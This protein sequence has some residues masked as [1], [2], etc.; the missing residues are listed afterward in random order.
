[1][2]VSNGLIAPKI[3]LIW[4]AI[5]DYQSSFQFTYNVLYCYNS[6]S[7]SKFCLFPPVGY[8]TFKDCTSLS[9]NSSSRTG[10]M[11]LECNVTSLFK[12]LVPSL[13]DIHAQKSPLVIIFSVNI[14]NTQS[15]SYSTFT[16]CDPMKLGIEL[17]T[18]SRNLILYFHQLP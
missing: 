7:L 5:D 6:T 12:R 3:S 17:C 1:M 11:V 15:D 18:F 14:G 2:C 8:N 13:Y 16:Y 4:N 9:V 10:S